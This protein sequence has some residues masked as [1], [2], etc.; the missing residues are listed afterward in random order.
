MAKYVMSLTSRSL[1]RDCPGSCRLT[2][3]AFLSNRL[4]PYC[5]I[6]PRTKAESPD[7]DPKL[8]ETYAVVFC[9]VPRLAFDNKQ[10]GAEHVST[11]H[12]SDARFQRYYSPSGRCW[13]KFDSLSDV[14]NLLV[15]NVSCHRR[16]DRLISA[17]VDGHL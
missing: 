4:A 14:Y 7:P 15:R 13:V 17:W 1:I 12:D 10:T 8:D 2:F 6:L 3:F 9:I 11:E 5:S 16:Q